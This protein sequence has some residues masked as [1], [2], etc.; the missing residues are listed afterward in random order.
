MFSCLCFQLKGQAQQ[1]WD[2]EEGT[3][4]VPVLE[5]SGRQAQTKNSRKL[6]LGQKKSSA[7]SHTPCGQR[8]Q[9]H[10]PPSQ[11][12]QSVGITAHNTCQ[13]CQRLPGRKNG[14]VSEDPCPDRARSLDAENWYTHEKSGDMKLES[15]LCD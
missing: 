15:S 6:S 7:K 8:E 13:R 2:W 12:D 5:P 10:A 1:R 11:T 3:Y 9:S 4:R 14:I